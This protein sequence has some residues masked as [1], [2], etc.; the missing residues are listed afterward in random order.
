MAWRTFCNDFFSLLPRALES[1]CHCMSLAFLCAKMYEFQS[2][3]S[4]SNKRVTINADGLMEIP[5]N[6][7]TT[8]TKRSFCSDSKLQ[9]WYYTKI[10]EKKLFQVMWAKSQGLPKINFGKCKILSCGP[11]ETSIPFR[12][13]HQLLNSKPLSRTPFFFRLSD[14]FLGDFILEGFHVVSTKKRDKLTLNFQKQ[15]MVQESSLSRRIC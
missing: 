8:S 4:F 11:A 2:L 15:I 7:F 12:S 5:C 14:T 9:L 6:S 10:C 3:N 13:L 1:S